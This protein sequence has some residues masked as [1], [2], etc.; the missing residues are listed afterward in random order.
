MAEWEWDA[1]SRRYRN[2][3]TGRYLSA[4]SSIDLRDDVV[5]RLKSEADALARRLA[6]EEIAV[7]DW[8]SAMQRN[9]REVNG[10]QW[11]FGRG[12]RYAMGTED[13]AAL[14][15][16]IRGQYDYL[17]AFAEQIAAGTLSEAQIAA[18]ARLYYQ[19]ST[20]AYE[21]GHAA[22]WNVSLPH[23]P[24]DGST[25]CKSAC[26]CRW[27]IR[28]SGDEIHATWRLQSGESCSTCKSYAR[29]YA[30]LV[31]AKSGD[32]RMARLFRMVA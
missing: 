9:I 24:A 23:Y 18:R 1:K 3:D 22:A 4:S 21:Q 30:P 6:S 29:A 19:S 5:N 2:V 20:Q 8:E 10:V 31:I 32:G 25:V 16:L 12:G 7:Q 17:R 28:E 11:A 14:A 13:R 26:R 15:D 27:D